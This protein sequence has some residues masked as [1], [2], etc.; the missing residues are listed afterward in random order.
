MLPHSLQVKAI[1]AAWQLLSKEDKHI[2]IEELMDDVGYVMWVDPLYG[3]PKPK[4]NLPPLY[5]E[6]DFW[7]IQALKRTFPSENVITNETFNRFKLI[8]DM[9]EEQTVGVHLDFHSGYTKFIFYGKELSDECTPVIPQENPIEQII[10]RA[11]TYDLIFAKIHYV[12][13]NDAIVLGKP[14]GFDLPL[15]SLVFGFSKHCE[16]LSIAGYNIEKII[17]IYTDQDQEN[18]D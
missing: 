3:A 15:S 16:M 5:E 4:D 10:L 2:A 12:R 18:L 9:I 7:I 13:M 11:L 6:R 1:K 8:L 14:I 17:P